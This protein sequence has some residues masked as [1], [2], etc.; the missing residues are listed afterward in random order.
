MQHSKIQTKIAELLELIGEDSKRDGLLD[1]PRRVA[2]AYTEWFRGYQAPTFNITSF[3]SKYTGIVA[4]RGIPFQSFCEHHMAMYKGTIDFGY[5][6]NGFVVGISKIPRLFQH[7][8]AKLTIQEELTDDLLNKF[9]EQFP[10]VKKPLGAIIIITANHTC[11]SS[12]G[13]KVD[14]PTTTSSVRGVFAEKLSPRE[15]FLSL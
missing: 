11:E 2:D 15:E 9:Y 3:P 8:S 1:T 5:I 14:V 10:A 4:R 6:P 13:V 12:R 7:Y